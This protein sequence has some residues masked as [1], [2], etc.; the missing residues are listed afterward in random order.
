MVRF[1]IRSVTGADT[2]TKRLEAANS[3]HELGK[4]LADLATLPQSRL[5]GSR[6][7]AALETQV[8]QKQWALAKRTGELCTNLFPDSKEAFA[9]LG[10]AYFETGLYEAAANH[11]DHALELNPNDAVLENLKTKIMERIKQ[12]SPE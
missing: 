3:C 10:K 12:Q 5:F 1:P 9:A 6:I 11:V 7:I 2:L 8:A 4:V